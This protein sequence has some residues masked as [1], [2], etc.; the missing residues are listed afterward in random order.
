MIALQDKED[1]C[2]TLDLNSTIHE[3]LPFQN[4]F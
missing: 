2:N 1:K 3:W 4:L